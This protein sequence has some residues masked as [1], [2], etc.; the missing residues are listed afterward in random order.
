K[1]NSNLKD[2]PLIIM[3]SDS[4]DE[5]FEQHKRLRT[6]AEDYVHKPVSVEQLIERIS[7]FV[8]LKREAGETIEDDL[9]IE[10]EIEIE[11]EVEEEDGEL[12]ALTEAAFGAITS[13]S[14]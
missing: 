4:T 10:D 2:V 3:S 7:E 14:K 12:E 13:P 9:V 6:R 5:T 1:R 8:Q 11:D